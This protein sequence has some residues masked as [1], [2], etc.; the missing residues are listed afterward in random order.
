MRRF[1]GTS[2]K[3][4][5]MGKSFR[6]SM[7]KPDCQYLQRVSFQRCSKL[8]FRLENP[9]LYNRECLG[10]DKVDTRFSNNFVEGEGSYCFKLGSGENRVR[11]DFFSPN[12]YLVISLELCTDIILELMNIFLVSTRQNSSIF[13]IEPQILNSTQYLQTCLIRQ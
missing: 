12:M 7:Q 4:P 1:F 5:F 13:P 9:T 11:V 8:V 10:M 3:I 2:N 6:I